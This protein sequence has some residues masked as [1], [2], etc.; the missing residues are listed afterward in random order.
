MSA[1]LEFGLDIVDNS[2]APTQ[3]RVTT[4]GNTEIKAKDQSVPLS[5]GGE[6][7]GAGGGCSPASVGSELLIVGS[8]IDVEAEME[9]DF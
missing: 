1:S 5:I 8:R 9:K 4:R 2:I 7:V 6:T 3:I